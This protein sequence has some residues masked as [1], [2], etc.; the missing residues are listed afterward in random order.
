MTFPNLPRVLEWEILSRVPATSLTR[1]RYTCRR[2]YA[3]FKNPRFIEKHSG[4][5]AKHF[6]L[7]KDFGVYSVNID[8]H[9]INKDQR[10]DPSILKD[11]EQTMI[12][13][14]FHCE[15]LF[16][17]TTKDK[18]I[19]VWNPCTGQ[20]RW[21]RIQPRSGHFVYDSYSLGYGNNKNNYSCDSFKILR[22][23]KHYDNVPVMEFEL[24]DFNTDS[25][26]L[27]AE[28][29]Q[30]SLT[31]SWRWMITSR[32][33]SLKGNTYWV[34]CDRHEHHDSKFLL[35]FDFKEERFE[36][37]SLPDGGYGST[38]FL[39]V[40]REEKL[41]VLFERR[42]IDSSRHLKI[43]VTDNKIDE[44]KSMTYIQYFLVMDFSNT[45]GKGTAVVSFLLDEE[46]K[47]VVC[48]GLDT[49]N[50]NKTIM[51]IVG[52]DQESIHSCEQILGEI[53]QGPT[54]DCWPFLE[55][56]VPSLVQIQQVEAA[57]AEG[58]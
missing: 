14:I 34:A 5:A 56:Y 21:I 52:G 6:I 51:Y 38:V 13:A 57:D 41:A 23:R 17:C 16:L 7:K 32:G 46:N 3:L 24:Y 28:D 37:F 35:R 31:V 1:F 55:S 50:R 11:S 29:A 26:R 19:V 47:K 39:S 43:W 44:A 15:G 18:R 12:H 2:W 25:W 53:A 42:N 9:G 20:T 48:C 45:L 30:S 40:V 10:F 36:R 27:L 8:L 22:C 54:E 58:D 49:R 33:V 4:K